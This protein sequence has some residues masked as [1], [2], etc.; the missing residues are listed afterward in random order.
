M[1]F[2]FHDRIYALEKDHELNMMRI[3]CIILNLS[4]KLLRSV[5]IFIIRLTVK[6]VTIYLIH[7][8]IIHLIFTIS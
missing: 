8:C 3:L 4:L 5:K 2:L 1:N 7:S 6:F